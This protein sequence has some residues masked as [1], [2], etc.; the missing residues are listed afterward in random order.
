MRLATVVHVTG[1]LVRLF[2]SGRSS[3]RRWS[4]SIYGEMRDAVGLRRRRSL[5]TAVA[6][7]THATRRRRRPGDAVERLRRVEGLA[8]VAATWMAHRSTSRRFRT[9]GRGLGFI[10]ALF[11]SMSGLTTTGATV[12]TD[13]TMFGRGIFFWRALTHWLGGVGVIALFIAVLPRL[14]IGGRE[15]FFA[16]AA[17]PTD[18]KLTPQ[19]RQTAIALWKIYGAL[20]AA[21]VVA[22]DA[23]G[24]VALR[25]GLSRVCDDGGWRILAASASRSPGTRA[26]ASTGSSPRSCSS[27]A[28]TS[29]CSIA[30]CAAAATRSCRTRSSARTP[31]RGRRVD[32]PGRCAAAPG[33][34][35]SR[36]DS[37]QRVSGGVDP[38]DDR[39]RE[40]RFQL[41]ERPG[42]RWSCSC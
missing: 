12:F 8:I 5:A 1:T 30:P 15:L 39:L 35:V 11:E 19:L 40:R 16:E 27:P 24:H 34:G 26:P 32:H 38:H 41:V 4:P 22:L 21:Q 3:H 23:R 36:R 18:E 7:H 37:S 14:A 10:D 31:G 33:N 29:R 13:F 25:R 17:G 28:P 9:C 42:A 6:R 20:T 2:S